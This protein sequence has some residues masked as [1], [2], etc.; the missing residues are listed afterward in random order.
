MSTTL[1]TGIMTTAGRAALAKSFG[2]LKGTSGQ[3][4][5]CR[6]KYFKIGMGGYTIIGDSKF[7]KDPDPALTDIESVTDPEY[8][9]TKELTA[10][11]ITFIA[12]STIQVR[13]SLVPVE[14]N[15]DG[16]G[17]SPRFFELGVFDENNVMICYATFGEQSKS[18]NKVLTNFLQVYF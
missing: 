5:L 13:C 3:F 12:P 2:N 15:D 11:D 17:N 16:S 4:P 8:Y 18:A 6:A 10:L 9:F 7:P 1:L 14:A